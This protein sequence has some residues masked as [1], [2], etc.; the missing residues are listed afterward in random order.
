MQG[1]PVPHTSCRDMDAFLQAFQAMCEDA[2]IPA[3]QPLMT[4]LYREQRTH[5]P[6]LHTNAYENILFGKSDTAPTES[7][8]EFA[9]GGQYVVPRTHLKSQPLSLWTSIH[10]MLQAHGNGPCP[11]DVFLPPVSHSIDAWT[12]ERMWW[13]AFSVRNPATPGA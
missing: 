13:L 2:P 6:T 4:S 5:C 12:M 9:A 11:G 10:T 7:W 3:A 8:I 1:D